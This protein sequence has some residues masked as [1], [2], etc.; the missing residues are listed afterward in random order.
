MVLGQVV[1]VEPGRVGGLEQTQALLVGVAE[2]RIAAV[3]PVEDAVGQ[4][5]G[6]GR[7]GTVDG[8]PYTATGSCCGISGGHVLIC[9]G[10]GGKP[11]TFRY[12]YS[13]HS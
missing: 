10:S 7:R 13:R 1:A 12:R 2:H 11:S 4:R 5:A 6:A 3:E 9:T 8:H